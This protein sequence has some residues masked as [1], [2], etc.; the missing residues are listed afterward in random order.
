MVNEGQTKLKGEAQDLLAQL[1]AALDQ[2]QNLSVDLC[3]EQIS[4][5]RRDEGKAKKEAVS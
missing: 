4:P 2:I 3:D 5:R 1:Q